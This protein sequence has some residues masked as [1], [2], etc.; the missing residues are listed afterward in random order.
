MLLGGSLFEF[1][2]SH[3]QTIEQLAALLDFIVVNVFPLLVLSFTDTDPSQMGHCKASLPLWV[4]V[5]KFCHFLG[6][7]IFL[8]PVEE[9]R[10]GFDLLFSFPI[11]HEAIMLALCTY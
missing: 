3:L 9:C 6:S 2:L 4:L 8:G 7:E 5:N 1:A 10:Y 11:L